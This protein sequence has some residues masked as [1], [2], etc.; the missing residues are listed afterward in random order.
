V[1]PFESIIRALPSSVNP[2]CDG[3]HRG[4]ERNSLSVEK[5]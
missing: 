5:T 1:L 3:L 4:V 2:N